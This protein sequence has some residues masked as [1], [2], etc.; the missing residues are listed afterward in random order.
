MKR[1]N[2]SLQQSG[3]ETVFAT[4]PRK[5]WCCPSRFVHVMVDSISQFELRFNST[6]RVVR[7]HTQLPASHINSPN[8]IFKI[9]NAKAS[10]GFCILLYFQFS[11]NSTDGYMRDSVWD[12]EHWRVMRVHIQLPAPHIN[13]SNAIFIILNAKRSV[14]FC[15]LLYFQ[16]SQNSTGGYLWDSV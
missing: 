4:P 7:V 9:L 12:C 15:I 13:P 6:V 14:D 11:Q 3:K 10:V 8:A 1:Q 5:P 2:F 16:F